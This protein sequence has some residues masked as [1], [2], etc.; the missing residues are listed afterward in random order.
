MEQKVNENPNKNIEISNKPI[1]T[2][3]GKNIYLFRYDNPSVKNNHPNSQTSK[4]ELVGK[5]FTDSL[6]LLKTYIQMRPPGGLINITYVPKDKLEEFRAINHPIA[7]NMDIEYS[8]FI[9]PDKLTKNLKSIPLTIPSVNPNQ[10]L[11]KDDG[12]IT[13]FLKNEVLPKLT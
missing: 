13:D 8:N 1:E 10:Y 7:K 3:N 9:L 11:F 5:W 4:P 12:K 2:P 6:M